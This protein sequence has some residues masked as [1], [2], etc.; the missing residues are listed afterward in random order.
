LNSGVTRGWPVGALPEEI[1]RGG[2]GRREDT[3]KNGWGGGAQPILSL[4]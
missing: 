1:G 4:L 3:R 2:G